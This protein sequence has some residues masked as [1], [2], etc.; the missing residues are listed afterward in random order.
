VPMLHYRNLLSL[1]TLNGK[2]VDDLGLDFTTVD[3][4]FGQRKVKLQLLFRSLS[5]EMKILRRIN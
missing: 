5:Q 2:E 4:N 1:K 3:D